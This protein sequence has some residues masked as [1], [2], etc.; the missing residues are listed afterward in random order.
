MES[1]RIHSRG[2]TLIELLVVI[3]IIAVLIALLLPAV[4]AA[5]EAARRASCVNNMKQIGLAMHNYES[6]F[7][8]FPFGVMDYDNSQTSAAQGGSKQQSLFN[9]LLTTMEQSNIYNSINFS[10]QA[11]GLPQR[12]AFDVEIASY[13]CPSDSKITRYTLA[14][15]SN[16]Y[17]QSSYAANAGTYDTIRYWQGDASNPKDI[18]A[19]GAF[20]QGFVFRISEFTDGL[21]STFMIGETSRFINDTE[22]VKNFGNRYGWWS[23]AIANVSRPSVIAL[24]T[25]RLNASILVPDMP[26]VGSG[27]FSPGFPFDDRALL[28][29]QFGFRSLHPGGANFLFGDGSVK[30]LKNS[31]NTTIYR[32]L[33]TRTKGE[34]LSADSY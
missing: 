33:S 20:S 22:Q 18:M 15:S 16:G 11:S 26:A 30:F 12:T 13:V 25:P 27:A 24:S 10:L 29:G 5:R 1:R 23:T 19:D 7:G 9:Y 28:M 6:A 17:Y 31:I 3:A 34:V 14:Q 32:A 2:F 4:Q 21:S 8:S